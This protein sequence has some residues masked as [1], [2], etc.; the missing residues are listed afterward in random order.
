MSMRW[1]ER[2]EYD[3][4]PRRLCQNIERPAKSTDQWTWE[5]LFRAFLPYSDYRNLVDQWP[6]VS[7]RAT[8]DRTRSLSLS[9][10]RVGP[11]PELLQLDRS[12]SFHFLHRPRSPR[13]LP[14]LA[15]TGDRTNAF[16]RLYQPMFYLICCRRFSSRYVSVECFDFRTA[17]TGESSNRSWLKKESSISTRLIQFTR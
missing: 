1:H 9:R 4:H 16:I 15:K 2:R 3:W 17:P 7:L 14:H 12:R 13:S 5:D 8:V 10:H 6:I 11:W